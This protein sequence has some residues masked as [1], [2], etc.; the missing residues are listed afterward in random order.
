MKIVI[1]SMIFESKPRATFE[2]SLSTVRNLIGREGTVNR[3]SMRV[4]A[5]FIRALVRTLLATELRFRVYALELPVPP[6][7]SL[8]RV[9]LAAIRTQVSLLARLIGASLLLM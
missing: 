7:G 1:G 6:E 2:S 8:C 4:H 9:T 3:L 5:P